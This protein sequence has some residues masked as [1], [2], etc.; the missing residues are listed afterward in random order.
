ILVVDDDPR[1]VR[2]MESILKSSGYP[3]LT[4]EDGEQALEVI[5]RDHP[6]AVRLD[7]MMPRMRGLELCRKLRSQYETRLLPIIMVTAL[8]ALEE[9]VQA[10]ETGAADFL[11]KPGN[12][13][14]L[15][16]QLRA[17]T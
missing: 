3:V 16:S 9:K 7:V 10:L 4:A 12:R 1:N 2:L 15:L 14:E 5:A 17:N 13:V 8:N 11:S 6:D